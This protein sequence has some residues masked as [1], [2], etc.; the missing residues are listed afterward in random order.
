MAHI[1]GVP[2]VAIPAHSCLCHLS[3]GLEVCV[4]STSPCGLTNLL[5]CV[6]L[7][8]CPSRGCRWVQNFFGVPSQQR[9]VRKWQARK[10]TIHTRRNFVSNNLNYFRQGLGECCVRARVCV[11]ALLC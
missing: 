5:Q 4:G 7:S 10:R 3:L 11:C 2:T 6:C 9:D 1:P 8:V